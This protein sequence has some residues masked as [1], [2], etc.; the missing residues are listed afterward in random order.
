MITVYE[1]IHKL[2]HIQHKG[3]YSVLGQDSI[4]LP[5]SSAPYGSYYA[6][7]CIPGTSVSIGKDSIIAECGDAPFG[8]FVLEVCVTGSYNSPGTNTSIALCATIFAEDV[9]VYKECQVGS[10]YSVGSD[11]KHLP[12]SR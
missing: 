12:C 9:Y 7:S 2:F 5:C 10:M 3:N 4:I 1:F 11:T 6:T 8:S